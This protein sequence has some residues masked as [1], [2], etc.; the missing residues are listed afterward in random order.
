VRLEGDNERTVIRLEKVSEIMKK[1]LS[2][3]ILMAR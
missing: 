1:Y 2:K 3:I